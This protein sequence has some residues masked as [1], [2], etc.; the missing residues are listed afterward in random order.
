MIYN[1]GSVNVDNV[2]RVPHLVR[3]GETL[4]STH[5]VQVL[6]GKGANQSLAAARAGAKVE[7]LGAIGA[8]DGWILALLDSAGIGTRHLATLDD[9]PS[10][11]TVIQVDDQAENSIV[12]FPGANRAVP[13]E[14]LEAA[15]TAAQP[16]DWLLAQNECG[17]LSR[18]IELALAKRL[19]IALNPAPMEAMIAGLPLE[20]IDMLFV[21]RGEAQMLLAALGDQVEEH[22]HQ[23][24][25]DLLAARYP[26]LELVLTLGG[27]G[28]RYANGELR[29]ARP[30]FLVEA[31]D[32]TAAGDTFVGY[33]LAARQQGERPEAALALAS[34]ASALCV[35]RE[36]ASSSIP[37]RDEVD[38]FIAA[39]A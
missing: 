9:I 20:R 19:R 25:L 2:Y 27:D 33:F 12:L 35:Q 5:Y 29:L 15:I 10:G 23:R 11:H 18:V 22:D 13:N 30:A 24:M 16:G 32:T 1:F 39:Q 17:D 38:A 21:N 37:E 31:R 4:A 26:G 28:V 6:G 7:H 3:P 34:A 14:H 36:G 8:A